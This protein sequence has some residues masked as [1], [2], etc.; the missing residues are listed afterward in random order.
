MACSA[1]TACSAEMACSAGTARLAGMGKGF[2]HP[3]SGA[4]QYLASIRKAAPRKSLPE[5]YGNR[6]DLGG[7]PTSTAP[8]YP[9]RIA[10]SQW[11]RLW[12]V[13]W[14]PPVLESSRIAHSGMGKC[15]IRGLDT[16]PSPLGS[17]DCEGH[18][19]RDGCCEQG[20][21]SPEGAEPGSKATHSAPRNQFTD[22]SGN[23][24]LSLAW[25]SIFHLI[26]HSCKESAT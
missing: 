3:R 24:G 25:Q 13:V 15:H 7:A 14:M 6:I 2:H 23:C 17:R 9:A 18:Q 20:G 10:N 22:R 12:M 8:E 26:L 1:G 21:K 4:T 11:S 19:A 16:S 5:S